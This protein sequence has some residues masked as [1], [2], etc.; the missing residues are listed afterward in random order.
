MRGGYCDTGKFSKHAAYPR[1]S[2]FSIEES[3]N[4]IFGSYGVFYKDSSIIYWFM[5]V[6]KKI[7]DEIYTAVR[8]HLDI[9]FV[10][11]NCEERCKFIKELYEILLYLVFE[12]KCREMYSICTKYLCKYSMCSK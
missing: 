4:L 2:N 9:Y 12:I 1:F 7:V 10:W 8:K 11:I 3:F 6:E 5:K